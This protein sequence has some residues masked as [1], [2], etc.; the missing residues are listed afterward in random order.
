LSTLPPRETFIIK[1]RF[2]SDIAPTRAD[3]GKKLGLS[4]E[5][6]RQLEIRALAKLKEI[7]KPLT[8]NGEFIEITHRVNLKS[9]I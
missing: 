6:V 8:E 2:F 1:Q 3:L 7:L 9:F 5:R 4:K